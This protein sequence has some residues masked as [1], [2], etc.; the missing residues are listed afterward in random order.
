M[1]QFKHIFMWSC[2]SVMTV[3]IKTFLVVQ[4]NEKIVIQNFLAK[5]F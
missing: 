1:Q 2:F 4:Y 3:I 5:V